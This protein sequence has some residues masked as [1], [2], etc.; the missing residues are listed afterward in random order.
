MRKQTRLIFNVGNTD[1]KCFYTGD[2]FDAQQNTVLRSARV[3]VPLLMN[4]V[5]PKSVLDVGC[6]TGAWLKAFAENGVSRIKGLD[7]L[8]V[9]PA[10]LLIPKEC[11]EPKDLSRPFRLP[12]PNDLT[13][14]LEVAEHLPYQVGQ[15]LVRR[16]TESAP[17]VLFSAALPGQR[18]VHHINEQWPGYWRALFERCGFVLLD[19]IR[20][21]VLADERVEWW[22]RQNIVLFA[23]EQVIQ[24]CTALQQHRIPANAPSIQWVRAHTVE[25]YIGVRGLCRALPGAIL[26]ALRRRLSGAP[27]DCL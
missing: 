11:F 25:R 13:V 2:F 15:L 19:P 12:G 10:K 16:L 7:G 22:Y 24:E 8:Y 23:A 4:I 21:L 9:D 6:A 20:P 26:H 14:C 5:R 1:Q 17:L 18:G 27:A 3:I